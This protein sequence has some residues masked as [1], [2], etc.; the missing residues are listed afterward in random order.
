[1]FDC[2]ACEFRQYV[3]ALDGENADAWRRYAA[4]TA[5]RWVYDLQAA[6]WRLDQVFADLDEDDREE[7]MTRV[8]IIYDA[9]HP[10]TEKR[11]G[12]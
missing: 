2:G 7:T 4:L 1:M 8:S 3:D 9:M 10:P 11:R 6:A 12:A 5:H